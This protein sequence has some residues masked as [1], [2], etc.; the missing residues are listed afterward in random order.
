MQIIKIY[1]E[2]RR[3]SRACL[4]VSLYYLRGFRKLVMILKNVRNTHNL[5]K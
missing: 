1:P 2:N 5:I 4:E 3:A